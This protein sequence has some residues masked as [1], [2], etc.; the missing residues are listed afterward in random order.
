MIE[1]AD[2]AH[3]PPQIT[4]TRYQGLTTTDTSALGHDR[5]T[6]NNVYHQPEQVT[7]AL[8]GVIR[9]RYDAEGHAIALTYDELGHKVAL[10]DPSM[11]QCTYGY[12]AFGELIEQTDASGQTTHITYDALGRQVLRATPDGSTRWVHDTRQAG[13]LSEVAR[14]NRQQQAHHRLGYDY[15]DRGRLQRVSQEIPGQDTLSVT[16][17]YDDQGRLIQRIYPG[18]HQLDYHYNDHGYL[19]RITSPASLSVDGYS[20]DRL[21]QLSQE[22]LDIARQLLD[23]HMDWQALSEQYRIQARRYLHYASHP[24]HILAGPG[25]RCPGASQPD[26]A[27]QWPGH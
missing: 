27:R 6:V 8:G 26:P 17:H 16:H 5:I 22:A 10:N 25:L 18:N 21:L 4:R 14:Y 20:R 11:G 7:D 13:Q 19:S 2:Q 23:D 3:T 1:R 12:N 9:Y 15:D 24:H